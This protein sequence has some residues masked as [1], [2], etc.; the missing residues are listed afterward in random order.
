M[1]RR[2]LPIS[3]AVVAAGSLGVSLTSCN[4]PSCGSGTVQQQQKDGTLKCVAVG[5]TAGQIPCDVDAGMVKLVGGQCVPA[6]T[7]DPNSTMTSNGICY[8]TGNTG[9]L[10][11]KTPA[12]DKACISGTIFNFTTNTKNTAAVDALLFN[13]TDLPSPN[14]TPIATGMVSAD[15]STYVFQDFTA[16]GIGLVVIATGTTTT[17]MVPTGTGGQGIANDTIYQIDAYALSQTDVAGW[18]FDITTGGGYIA[19]F[20]N[21]PKSADPTKNLNTETHPQLGVVL[22]QDGQAPPGGLKF[23]NDTLTAIDPTLTATGNSGTAIAS[24]PIASGGT[25]SMFTGVGGGITWETFPGGSKA[26]FV[27]VTRFHPY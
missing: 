3:I 14:P 9:T 10:S 5:E 2:W 17:G 19:R 21:D 13:A 8:G 12:S 18:N 22:T 4:E 7:C 26:N 23:F 11:C 20:F 15:G 27:L 1:N 24:A 16:P 25:F 6:V